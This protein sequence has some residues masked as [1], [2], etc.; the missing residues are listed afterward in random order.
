VRDEGTVS[1]RTGPDP[2]GAAPEVI[3]EAVALLMRRRRLT[4]SDAFDRLH[5]IATEVG[6]KLHEAATLVLSF[7]EP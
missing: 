5:E 1:G 2:S 6:I 4:R 7:E 3:H